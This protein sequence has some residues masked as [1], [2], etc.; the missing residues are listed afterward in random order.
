[1]NKKAVVLLSGGLDST[2]VL[3]QAKSEGY[4]LYALSFDYGQR[5][6]AELDAA[7]AI[8]GAMGVIEHKVVPMD[9]SGI[10]GSALT[11]ASIDVPTTESDGIPVTYV[12]ARNTVFLSIA[13]GWAEVLEAQDIFIGVSAVDYSGY[14][15]CRP[16]YIAAYER[17]ANLATKM[18]VEGRHIR[19]RT[20]L[21]NL[22]KA[23]TIQL[24][25]RLGVDYSLT[26]SC[27]QANTAGEACGECDS[28]RL[29]IKGFEEAGVTD[30]TRYQA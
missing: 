2:T 15:D 26:V 10:G 19:I 22:T 6:D 4:D 14:P 9:L 13:L 7:R 30:P 8:A 25:D 18:G 21:I 29:R 16:E 11:D 24:G 3:A 23:A 1:M 5:H 28:C 20:P 12:P 27:Y 17:L